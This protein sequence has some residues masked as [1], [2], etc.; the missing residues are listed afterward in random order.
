MFKCPFEGDRCGSSYMGQDGFCDADTLPIWEYQDK[1]C[2]EA[3]VKSEENKWPL[4]KM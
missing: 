2:K 3:K 4:K 1:E